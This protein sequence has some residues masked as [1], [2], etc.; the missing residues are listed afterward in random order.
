MLGG[1]DGT[2]GSSDESPGP[3]LS[4][5]WVLA[6]DWDCVGL[7]GV[8]FTLEGGSSTADPVVLRLEL[9]NLHVGINT[10]TSG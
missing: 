3:P 9:K 4:S 1:G 6:Q 10:A 5:A 8:G 7:T 2:G